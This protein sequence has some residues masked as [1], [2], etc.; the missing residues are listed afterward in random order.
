MRDKYSDIVKE[1][2]DRELLFHLYLTQLLLLVISLILGFLLFDSFSDFTALFKWADINII[3]IGGTA[4]IIVVLIDLALMRVLPSS[5]YDDGGLNN[6]IF[7]SPSLFQI[8]FITMLVAF[9]EEILFRGV[10]QTNFGLIVSSIIF[11]LVHYRYLFNWFLFLNVVLLSFLIG[12]VYYFTENL[13]VTILMHFI[14]DFLLGMS[15]KYR[16]Q[17]NR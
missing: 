1:L 11:A 12:F 4:G 17:Y 7:R 6:K 2:T 16:N 9:S 10:I 14:I 15:I 5:Y 8:A 3:I 13:V